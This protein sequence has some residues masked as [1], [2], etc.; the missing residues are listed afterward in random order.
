MNRFSTLYGYILGALIVIGFFVLLYI[1]GSHEMPE[2]NTRLLDMCVGAL[3]QCFGWVVGYF[4]G[5]SQG[6]RMKTE[7]MAKM[8]EPSKMN[9]VPK[10]EPPIAPNNVIQEIAG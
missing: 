3:I 8:N 9:E 2:K 10:T 7:I 1:L 6:S 5:S 4:F